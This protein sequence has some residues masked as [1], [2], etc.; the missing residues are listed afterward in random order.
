LQGIWNATTLLLGTMAVVNVN[1]L[2][3]RI[4]GVLIDMSHGRFG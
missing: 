2:R 4:N 1:A 3:A